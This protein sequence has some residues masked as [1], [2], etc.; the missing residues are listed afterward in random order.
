MLNE[1]LSPALGS[2]FRCMLQ[3]NQSPRPV[4]LI[5]RITPLAEFL[6]GMFGEECRMLSS[7]QWTHKFNGDRLK[8]K[9]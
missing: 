2:A 4:T 1:V 3:Q 7:S 9:K 5:T 6:F 8:I